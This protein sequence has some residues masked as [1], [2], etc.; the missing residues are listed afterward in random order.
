MHAT[1]RTALFVSLLMTW[2]TPAAANEFEHVW[3]CTIQAGHNLDEVRS[4]GTDW[5]KA[6]RSMPGGEALQLVIRWPIAVPE[7]AEVFEFVVRATSLQ[8]WGR[9]Y[10]GYDPDSPAGKADE[11]FANIAT[12]SGSTLWESIS[13]AN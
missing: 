6:A 13:L 10:D 9:F 7:S 4:A 2:I 3:T 8:A 5:L 12:C 1:A 11:V